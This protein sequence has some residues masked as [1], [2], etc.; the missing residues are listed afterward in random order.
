MSNALEAACFDVCLRA[1]YDGSLPLYLGS[2]LRGAFG[3][4]FKK[5]ACPLRR[6][7]CLQCILKEKCVY[8]YVFETPKEAV[9]AEETWWRRYPQVPH[10]FIIEPP[11]REKREITA[12]QP[13]FFRLIL[14]GRA[15]DYLPYFVCAF[16][17]M[18]DQGL[19]A[20]RLKF[21]LDNIEA[22][23]DGKVKRIMSQRTKAL[24]TKYPIMTAEMIIGECQET[25]E[26][27]LN[28]L[29]PTLIKEKERLTGRPNFKLIVRNLLRRLS[30]LEKFHCG[31]E[32]DWDFSSLLK[33]AEGVRSDSRELSWQYWSRYS[34]RLGQKMEMGGLVGRLRFAGELKPFMPLLRLGEVFHLGKGAV[35]GLGKYKIE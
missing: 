28:L 27:I 8:S 3:W 34:S 17:E 26:V 18:A 4:A 31:H 25:S 14:I 2:T 7:T 13:L 24:D 32:P 5:V 19:G 11:V 12:N 10:P 15:R 22:R 21:E 6:Q 35:F 30:A 9:Q 1:R 29:T 16:Q 20:Q 23:A 33:A